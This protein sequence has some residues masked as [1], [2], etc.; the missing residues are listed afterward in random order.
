MR[1]RISPEGIKEMME[2]FQERWNVGDIEI[3]G[4]CQAYAPN[5]SALFD[6]EVRV[7]GRRAIIAH[8]RRSYPTA[9]SMGCLTLKL[10]GSEFVGERATT[11][12]EF[13]LQAEGEVRQGRAELTFAQ[14]N[15]QFFIVEEEAIPPSP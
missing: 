4:A 14:R 15:Q 5:A 8:Y 11:V 3:E 9:A 6:E 10:V 1:G 12:W 13:V 2:R 7:E